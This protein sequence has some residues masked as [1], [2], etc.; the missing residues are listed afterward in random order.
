MN[1]LIDNKE[2][3]INANNISTVKTL[4]L[5]PANPINNT[6][7]I[8]M[9]NGDKFVLEYF[10]YLYFRN[11]SSGEYAS[12][13]LKKYLKMDNSKVEYLQKNK[14]IEYTK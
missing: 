9:N 5:D 8:K 12:F 6:Y 10:S 11:Y 14:Y 1:I 13:D 7:E 4:N 2:V 3:F